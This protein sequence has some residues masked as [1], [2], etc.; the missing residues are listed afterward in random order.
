M[1]RFL[2]LW[3]LLIAS[4]A[5]AQNADDETISGLDILEVCDS[6]ELA[7]RNTCRIIYESVIW[8]A[9]IMAAKE[10]G[11]PRI[12]LP[13]NANSD[14]LQRIYEEHMEETG[15]RSQDLPFIKSMIMAYARSFPCAAP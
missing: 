14:M 3:I 8:G 4:P 15:Y 7:D 12:C 6:S 9:Q 2:A 10:N 1:F 13:E 5:L 11:K